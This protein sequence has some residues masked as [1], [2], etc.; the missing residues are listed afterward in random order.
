MLASGYWLGPL[1]WLAVLPF[2]GAA[3]IFWTGY[4]LQQSVQNQPA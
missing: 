2:G 4:N 1:A 3:L